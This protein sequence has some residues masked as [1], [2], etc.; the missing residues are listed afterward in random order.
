MISSPVLIN[1]EYYNSC[2]IA[3]K[4]LGVDEKTINYILK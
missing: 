4:Q 3:G 1:G 2:C